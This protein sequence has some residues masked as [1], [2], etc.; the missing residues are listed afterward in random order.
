VVTEETA[1]TLWP[2]QSAL[3]QSL[4]LPD[5][6]SVEWRQVVGIVRD[7]QFHTVG[8]TPGLHVFTPWTQDSASA[9][10]HILVAAEGEPE[11]LTP[12][13][14]QLLKTVEPG[15]SVDGVVS[16]EALV[17]R[18]TAQ[19]RFTS[20]LVV[21]FGA[22]AL[23]LAAVGIYG[24]LAYLVGATTREI[25]IRL[26]LGAQRQAILSHV[27]R[28]GLL[29]ALVGCA[30]G[31]GVALGLAR[32][33]RALLFG[34]EPIDPLSLMAGAVALIFVALGAAWGPARRAAGVDLVKALRTE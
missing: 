23:L 12:T 26:A 21:G 25:G 11:A 8:E 22:L 20:W 3:G 17:T 9:R 5:S 2:G 27:Y 24:T 30:V 28:H 18:A 4:Y 6:D 31:C 34:V 32:T 13:V 14:R 7:I 16:L 19:P 29:P 10:I 33:F 15:A 1:R